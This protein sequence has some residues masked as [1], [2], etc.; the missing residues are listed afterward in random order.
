[1][2]TPPLQNQETS[3]PTGAQSQLIVLELLPPGNESSSSSMAQSVVPAP[4]A[5]DKTRSRLVRL[6]FLLMML[7][8]HKVEER[9]MECCPPRQNRALELLHPVNP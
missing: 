4:L 5:R 6:E 2:S 9:T 1:M 8:P 3:G 7:L